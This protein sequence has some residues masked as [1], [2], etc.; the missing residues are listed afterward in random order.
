MGEVDLSHNADRLEVLVK[1]AVSGKESQG[2]SKA[3]VILEILKT[4]PG[5][6]EQADTTPEPLCYLVASRTMEE[7]R[8][9]YWKWE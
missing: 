5:E 2:K 8:P 9:V 4:F 1:A 7:L 6:S 3:P